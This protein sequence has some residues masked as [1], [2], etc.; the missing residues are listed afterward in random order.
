VST[1][2]PY[3]KEELTLLPGFGAVKAGEYGAEILEVTS[4]TERNWQFPLDWVEEELDEELFRSWT[5]KQKEARFKAEMERSAQRKQLLAGIRMGQSLAMLQEA[6]G[7]SRRETVEQLEQL[8]KEGYD[9]EPLI[10]L[11]LQAVPEREQIA[12]WEAYHEL[13]DALL[14]PVLQK[15]Y[16]AEALQ[17]SSSELERLYEWLRLIRIRYRKEQKRDSR[18]A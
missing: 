6:T 14:K 11:E 16:G 10:A 1:F 12:I 8:E 2:L 9:M 3:T 17:Q 4:L 13:G 7:L 15:V 18:S 5:Y